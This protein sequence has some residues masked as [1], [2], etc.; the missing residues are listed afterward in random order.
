MWCHCHPHIKHTSIAGAHWL[1]RRDIV[2]KAGQG[3]AVSLIEGSNHR[4]RKSNQACE[5]PVIMRLKLEWWADAHGFPGTRGNFSLLLGAP[6]ICLRNKWM[7]RGSGSKSWQV[8]GHSWHLISLSVSHFNQMWF[9]LNASHKIFCVLLGQK[10][11][12]RWWVLCEAGEEKVQRLSTPP[13]LMVKTSDWPG[14]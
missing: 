13:P 8:A 1:F 12:R 14:Q 2:K 3:G 10:L 7:R 11:E 6:A 9:P 4:I 5:D